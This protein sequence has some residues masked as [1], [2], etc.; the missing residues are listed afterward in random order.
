MLILC[1]YVIIMKG[2]LNKLD[3]IHGKNINSSKH[4]AT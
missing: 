1:F 2:A 4:Y 3:K